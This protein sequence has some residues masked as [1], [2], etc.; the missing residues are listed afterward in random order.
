MI[1]IFKF[2]T[3]AW[4]VICFDLVCFFA[5]DI[6]DIFSVSLIYGGVPWMQKFWSPL[7]RLRSC[8]KFSFYHVGLRGG[9]PEYSFI[10]ILPEKV[11]SISL[12]F[13]NKWLAFLCFL[14]LYGL[15][16]VLMWYV[17]CLFVFYFWHWGHIFCE[18]DLWWGTMDAEIL[19]LLCR[20]VKSSFY[21]VGL[22]RG[23]PEYS[24]ICILSKIL[25][26][27]FIQLHFPQSSSNQSFLY[28]AATKVYV[29]YVAGLYVSVP[30]CK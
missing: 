21:R 6:G 10:C 8:Q 19:V 29:I 18:F 3:A 15:C 22:S 17:F 4:F 26:S 14:L 30:A 11:W 23:W 16:S 13:A 25:P 12:P 1:G 27:W 9:W 5:F 2:L 7:L 24:F 28:Q 20:A